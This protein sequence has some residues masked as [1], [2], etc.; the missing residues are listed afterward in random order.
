MKKKLKII[1]N[2]AKKF[3]H[4]IKIYI[5]KVL[6]VNKIYIFIKRNSKL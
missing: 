6:K 4:K 1:C 3:I 2:N 5:K